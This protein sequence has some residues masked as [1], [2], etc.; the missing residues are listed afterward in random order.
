MFP[1]TTHDTIESTTTALGSREVRSGTHA[2]AIKDA[3][4]GEIAS[5]FDRMVD[6]GVQQEGAQQEQGS[7][8]TTGGKS[9]GA[10]ADASGDVLTEDVDQEKG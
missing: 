2:D 5:L 1:R 8:R 9:G 4:D 10:T 7:A 6:L 3:T